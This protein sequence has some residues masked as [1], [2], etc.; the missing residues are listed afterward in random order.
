[1]KKGVILVNDGVIS[2]KCVLLEEHFSIKIV[3]SKE[4]FLSLYPSFQ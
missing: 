1:M 3:L 4:H 2:D